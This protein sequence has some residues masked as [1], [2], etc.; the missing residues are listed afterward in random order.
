MKEQKMKERKTEMKKKRWV[1]N[2]VREEQ[3]ENQEIRVI[4]K[5]QQNFIALFA[6]RNLR[7]SHS[8]TYLFVS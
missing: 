8:R 5:M 6:K 4:Q 3:K 2:N 7:Q 1:P